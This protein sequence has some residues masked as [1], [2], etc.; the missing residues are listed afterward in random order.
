[1]RYFYQFLYLAIPAAV[2]FLCFSSYRRKALAAMELRS[3]KLREVFLL[4]FVMLISGIIALKIWPVYYKSPDSGDIM[5]LLDR[6]SWDAQFHYIPFSMF[7]DYY[8]YCTEYGSSDLISIMIN[9]GGNFIAFIPVGLLAELLFKDFTWKQTVI[10]GFAL[11]LFT[12]TAQYFIMR[13]TSIDDILLNTVGT[14]CGHLLFLLLRH[15]SPALTKKFQC[16]SI[17]Y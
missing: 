1:M 4:I 7:A 13:N 14:I 6:P 17:M 9:I 16:S 8:R 3:S 11:S 15:L 2:I 5:L 10:T 12:E